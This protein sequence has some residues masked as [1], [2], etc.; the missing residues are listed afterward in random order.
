MPVA[1]SGSQPSP[2]GPSGDGVV[3]GRVTALFRYPVKSMAGEAVEHAAVGSSGLAHDRAWAVYTEDGGIASGKR[4]R[5]FRPVPGL[6]RWRSVAGH[7][8]PEV[9]DPEGSRLRADDPAAGAALSAA[10]GRPLVLRPETDVPHHDESP[11]HLVTSSSLAALGSTGTPVDPRRFRPNIVLDTGSLP[12]FP[13]DSWAGGRL[14][15][16]PEVV[17]GVEAGMV[18]C[19]MVDQDQVGV[20]A[21]RPVLGVLGDLHDAHLGLQLRPVVLGTVRVG[22]DVRFVRD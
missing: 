22:D 15:V 19:V 5:R 16:G 3:V 1:G 11:L 10:F 4:T 13:E 7:D 20:T 17:L 18:R 9:L 14:H 6:M 21:D 12:G 8:V 2:G